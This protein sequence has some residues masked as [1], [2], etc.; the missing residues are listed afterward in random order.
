MYK[1]LYEENKTDAQFFSSNEIK[2][3]IVVPK[4]QKTFDIY[5]STMLWQFVHHDLQTYYFDI[6]SYKRIRFYYINN[7]FK[8]FIYVPYKHNIPIKKETYVV[9]WLLP[10]SYRNSL[11]RLVNKRIKRNKSK[12]IPHNTLLINVILDDTQT[13]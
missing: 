1:F 13:R 7:R 11:F 4:Y 9:A 8:V 10:T 12:R 6:L 2:T 5:P 3:K